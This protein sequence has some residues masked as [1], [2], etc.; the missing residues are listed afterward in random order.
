MSTIKSS[1]PE[2]R[3]ESGYEWFP[4]NTRGAFSSARIAVK[5]GGCL[6][7]KFDLPICLKGC[8]PAH[9]RG[10]I[11]FPDLYTPSDARRCEDEIY[12]AVECF[13]REVIRDIIAYV[14]GSIEFPSEVYRTVF[15]I[16]EE[17]VASFYLANDLGT[18]IPFPF[19]VEEAPPSD[20]A[21]LHCE[22]FRSILPCRDE[23]FQEPVYR[24]IKLQSPF[25]ERCADVCCSPILFSSVG[26]P[27]LVTWIT[28]FGA[29]IRLTQKVRDLQALAFEE[30]LESARAEV[31]NSEDQE[32]EWQWFPSLN[33][34]SSR[35]HIAVK[36]SDT[37][38]EFDLPITIT[39]KEKAHLS[40]EIQFPFTLYG[41]AANEQLFKIL[42]DYLE[43]LPIEI[44]NIILS[45]VTLPD[46]EL[47]EVPKTVYQIVIE[48]LSAHYLA[49]AARATVL[50]P[51]KIV[52][53]PLSKEPLS[54]LELLGSIVP[55][56]EDK[57]DE[58]VHH[59]FPIQSPQLA[60]FADRSSPL[61][62]QLNGRFSN[63]TWREVRALWE[64]LEGVF[65]SHHH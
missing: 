61:K 35:A 59:F 55:L 45:Y 5:V 13:P 1:L 62:N 54:L 33:T 20:A 31:E 3:L 49:K 57:M 14:I 42:Y 51:F 17:A 48:T 10:E 41:F 38:A 29:Y 9:F 21:L 63:T 19:K 24:S 15:R 46:K 52:K 65:H 4:E 12:N 27:P 43:S 18:T 60:A 16:A 39:G 64:R 44:L 50:F 28:L 53:D 22:L 58:P 25:L 11:N 34:P 40:G 6:P 8:E 37:R 32:N 26:D 36:V 2:K 56:Y 7:V 23:D 47:E 30:R